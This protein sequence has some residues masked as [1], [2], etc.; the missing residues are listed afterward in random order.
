MYFG[1]ENISISYGTK[2]VINNLTADFQ[3]GKITT[4][5]GPNGCGKSSILRVL[6]KGVKP[7][8]GF[9]I[10]NDKNVKSY[11]SKEIA[12]K[13]AILPQ[14]HNSPPDIDVKTLVSYGRYPY[15]KLGRGL[16]IKDREIVD[17]I[18]DKTGLSNLKDQ[19]LATLSGGE[20]QRAWIAMTICQQPE[21]LVLDEPTTYLDVNHQIEILELVRELNKSLGITIIMVLH[22][23][24]LAIR[25][26][27]Y[28]YAIKNGNIYYKGKPEDVVTKDFLADVFCLDVHMYKDNVNNCPYFIPKYAL[29]KQSVK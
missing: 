23:L 19:M 8:S 18:L 22:D 9:A 26:S 14:V 12:K 3:K 29:K 17:D 27:D 2:K 13:I 16:T 10:Y 5:I 7:I 28:L 4:I 25:Y 1:F 20:R 11:K 6:S 24:N 15:I 21:I